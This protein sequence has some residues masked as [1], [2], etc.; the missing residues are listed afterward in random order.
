MAT[1]E[2]FRNQMVAMLNDPGQL[3][4]LRGRVLGAGATAPGALQVKAVESKVFKRM[5]V[6]RGTSGQS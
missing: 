6:F 1:D 4:E 5:E 2:T 3:A